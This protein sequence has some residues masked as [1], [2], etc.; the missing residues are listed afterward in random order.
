[1]N[2][3]P[4]LKHLDLR[5]STSLSLDPAQPPF[6]FLQTDLPRLSLTVTGDSSAL[7]SSIA[8]HDGFGH[9][10]DQFF[11][12]LSNRAPNL[13][14]L[15]LDLAYIDVSD[16]QVI[17]YLAS[18][19][20]LQ[21]LTMNP[22]NYTSELFS[23]LAKF[24]NLRAIEFE[25]TLVQLKRTSQRSLFRPILQEG[26]FPELRELALNVAFDDMSSLL[27]HKYAPTRLLSQL[28]ITSSHFET[29][30]SIS[31]F[32]KVLTDSCQMLESLGL[33]MAPSMRYKES[34]RISYQELVVL[35]S[36]PNLRSFRFNDSFPVSLTNEELGNLVSSWNSLE[37]LY[38]TAPHRYGPFNLSSQLTLAC[39]FPLAQHC[40]KLREV[41]LYIDAT[42]SVG[43]PPTFKPFVRLEVLDI[44][45]SPIE[46]VY[47]LFRFLNILCPGARP[48]FDL[49]TMHSWDDYNR[50]M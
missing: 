21:K 30:E 49:D 13:T 16:S 28:H 50:W 47:E 5:L 32:L 20:S 39:L 45:K 2:I 35:R 46:D 48:K 1:M 10:V 43:L 36:L 15:S 9:I 24:S 31:T 22:A 34:T 41:G 7:D 38:L 25:R 44:G 40:P 17:K 23:E 6:I 27:S 11:V 19:R 37:T 42:I 4:N 18:L 26:A 12:E 29:A 3:F 14:T 33:N 8:V